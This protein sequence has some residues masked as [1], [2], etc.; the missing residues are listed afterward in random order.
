M[1]NQWAKHQVPMWRSR[2]EIRPPSTAYFDL[3][4]RTLTCL[5]PTNSK[6]LAKLA[7]FTLAMVILPL[8]TYF[9]SLEHVFGRRSLIRYRDAFSSL[10]LPFSY[11]NCPA[12]N[13]TYAAISAAV[14]AN[15][16]LVGFIIV[17]LAEDRQGGGAV[18][19][20]KDRKK[21]E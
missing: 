11:P 9:L 4:C 7:G 10:T 13:T 21:A 16:I 14:V 3:G 19:S 15:V 1:A 5:I 20:E 6:A 12:K 18:V 8:S 17:A 2:S